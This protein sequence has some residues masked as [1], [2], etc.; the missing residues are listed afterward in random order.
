[1]VF[2]DVSADTDWWR[3]EGANGQQGIF[4]SN[5]VR[6]LEDI[7]QEKEKGYYPG[8]QQ[9]QPY[10]APP[11]Q[12]YPGAMYQP[13]Q[14]APA[15]YQQAAPQQQPPPEQKESR[16]GRWGKNYGRTFVN[17]TAWYTSLQLKLLMQGRWNGIR[18]RCR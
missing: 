8:P 12:Q 17:A 14:Y 3:G 4:P 1:M 11:P 2:Y 16:F 10:S 13:T 5:Y 15:P 18:C 6:K 7:P 9:H